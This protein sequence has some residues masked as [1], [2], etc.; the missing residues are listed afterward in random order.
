LETSPGTDINEDYLFVHVIVKSHLF[1]DE[2]IRDEICKCEQSAKDG[3]F[4]LGKNSPRSTVQKVEL[5]L[6][7]KKMR[8][9]AD[10]WDISIQLYLIWV[11][12]K[13]NCHLTANQKSRV[14]CRL[15]P[16]TRQTLSVLKW[17]DTWDGAVP[18]LASEGWQKHTK[19]L[20]VYKGKNF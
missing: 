4:R 16:S 11:V 19:T 10:Y 1:R 6:I 9:G 13:F 14:Q 8:C 12:H 3:K 7:R 15:L 18:W 17:V 20:K 2:H 5:L